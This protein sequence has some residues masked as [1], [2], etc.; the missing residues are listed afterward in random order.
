MK[1][2]PPSKHQSTSL[3][4]EPGSAPDPEY[5]ED[6]DYTPKEQNRGWFFP[7]VVV[8]MYE[9]GHINAEEMMLLGKIN[10][11]VDEKKGC[12]AS[13]SYLSKWWG[14]T[15]QHV[16]RTIAKFEELG[17]IKSYIKKIEKQGT[18]R[19]IWTCF[20]GDRGGEQKCS[21]GDEHLG[22]GGVNK[23]VQCI[24]STSLIT[25]EVPRRVAPA[26][27]K[28]GDYSFGLGNK[29]SNL[30]YQAEAS[31]LVQEFYQYLVEKRLHLAR[32]DLPRGQDEIAKHKRESTFRKW[33][34]YASELIESLDGNTKP[35]RS[36]MKWYFQNYRNKSV[37]AYH[38]LNTFCENYHKLAKTM[39]WRENTE[40]SENT[41]E[42]R[43]LGEENLDDTNQEDVW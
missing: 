36:L 27:Q 30:P 33:S 40:E 11:L 26:P 8:R 42:T 25:N 13:N 32:A 21:G 16:S 15:T 4:E 39:S 1:Q 9:K 14:K 20:Q 37:G 3:K 31:Q 38:S 2:Y 34:Q 41:I 12:W 35:I 5:I 28:N 7:V 22:P 24:V 43:N 18:R 19:T 17:I 6:A 10:A 23:N 29:Q